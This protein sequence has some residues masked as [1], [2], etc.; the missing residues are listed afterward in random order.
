MV[1]A[2]GGGGDREGEGR[3]CRGSGDEERRGV[4]GRDKSYA[5]RRKC[6]RR[7]RRCVGSRQWEK[8]WMQELAIAL[9]PCNNLSFL[10]MTLFNPS[11]ST[12]ILS[13][14]SLRSSVCL[15]NCP[16]ESASLVI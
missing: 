16:C 10:A 14:V 12:L 3:V 9:S 15:V 5:D 1:W 11:H 8:R 13:L 7:G 6:E 2:Q 4:R